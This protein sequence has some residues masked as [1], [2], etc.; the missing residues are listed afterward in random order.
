MQTGKLS[1]WSKTFLSVGFFFLYAPILILVIFSFNKSELVTVWAGFSFKWYGELFRDPQMLG[2][3]WISLKIALLAASTSVVLGTMA[4]IV[5]VRMG[6][7]KGK[8]AFSSMI[9]A[10][11]VMPEVITGLSLLLLFV[12]MGQSLGWPGE[13]GILTI[14][15]AHV[16]FCTA[17]VAVV[18]SSRLQ[19]LDE[20]IEEAAQDLG[21]PPWK[22]FFLVTLPII[23]PALMSG[24]LLAFTLSLDDLVIA[25]FVSGPGST[26]LPMQVFSSVRMGISP[27]INALATLVIL[28][29]TIAVF[30]AWWIAQRSLKQTTHISK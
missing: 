28:A 21:A 2:A 24:W 20:S 17:F 11:L 23:A 29:A 3:A 16:T 14:W 8:T 25:S 1:T 26:T 9:T 12:A 13:R 4:S 5:M 27:Q 18:V 15:I 7:F 10:P 30:I 19:E 6:T 22:V